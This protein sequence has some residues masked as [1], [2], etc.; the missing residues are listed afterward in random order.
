MRTNNTVE[1]VGHYG[2]DE[3]IAL[4]AW[5]S[6]NRELTPDKKKRLGRF[7]KSLADNGHGT[8]FEKGMVHFVIKTDIATH[9]HLLKHRITSMNAESARYKE[10]KDD[11]FLIPQDL[12]SCKVQPDECEQLKHFEGKT[13]GYMLQQ[14]TEITNYLY[15]KCLQ[16]IEDKL[17]RKRG[18]EIAR[19]FKM[20]NSQI[21][22]DFMLNMRSFKNLYDQRTTE[23]AQRE[24]CAVVKNMVREIK[25]IPG[26]PFR[27]TL[28]ALNIK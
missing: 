26:N 14:T 11:D 24:V 23:H 16:D 7:L 28:K 4:S 22:Q 20:Y 13:W 1:L 8:P 9:I 19:Y 25:K 21:E 18:K 6:T 10:I 3:T 2:S 5:V 27:L 17:G 15:H 12:F